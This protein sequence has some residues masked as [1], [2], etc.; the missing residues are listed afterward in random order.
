ME[1]FI[2][3][4]FDNKLL[5]SSKTL[6]S[7]PKDC[8]FPTKH[9]YICY[10]NSRCFMFGCFML[11]DMIMNLFTNAIKQQMKSVKTKSKIKDDKICFY[12]ESPQDYSWKKTIYDT[13]TITC[14]SWYWKREICK[15]MGGLLYIVVD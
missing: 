3:P 7:G 12:Q 11:D 5:S 2:L 15:Y 14:T 10:Y 8:V 6:K 13:K 4:I 1:T 9:D